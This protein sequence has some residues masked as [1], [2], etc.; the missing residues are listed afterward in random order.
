VRAAPR[1]IDANLVI[2]KR[3]GTYARKANEHPGFVKGAGEPQ[4]RRHVLLIRPTPEFLGGRDK[5]VIQA[6]IA[7]V[8]PA[9]ESPRG[10]AAPIP[11]P[12]RRCPSGSY[13][14]AAGEPN[15]GDGYLNVF[16]LLRHLQALWHA[17]PCSGRGNALLSRRPI[18]RL[19]GWFLLAIVQ[20]RQVV[21]VDRWLRR[22][23][24]ERTSER[25]CR[26]GR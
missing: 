7:E 2:N 18:L 20:G 15:T 21:E 23:D 3:V 25:D 4:A 8:D 1:P 17:R 11:P 12:R 22:M 10:F 16:N 24:A 19:N 6:A 13:R 9:G 14:K 26:V 5:L